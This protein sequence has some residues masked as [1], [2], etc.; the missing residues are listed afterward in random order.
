MAICVKGSCIFVLDDGE[1]R[2]EIRLDSPN[3]GLLIEGLIW[4]EMYDF[5]PD[6]I[7][8]VLASVHYDEGDYIR[9][10]QEFI[11]EVKKTELSGSDNRT[12]KTDD[13]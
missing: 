7:L 4:R 9:N 10:Y 8:L 13:S 11:E 1:S 3:Q 2:E 12:T 6:C 5:S